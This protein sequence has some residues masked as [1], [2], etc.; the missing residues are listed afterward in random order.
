MIEKIFENNKN[1]YICGLPLEG[2]T[3]GVM[4]PLLDKIIENNESFIV[5]D[6]KEEYYREYNGLLKERG[7]NVQVIN[8]RN[9]RFSLA[10][11]PL[12]LPYKLYKKIL[13]N[14]KNC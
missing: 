14:L 3:L 4:M 12:L 1:K 13:I 11:N 2:K 7:Y 10:Y 5:I 8:L 6:S 9:P